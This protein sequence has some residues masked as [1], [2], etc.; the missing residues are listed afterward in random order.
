VGDLMAD[1]EA[2]IQSQRLPS[3]YND[4]VEAV[5][6]PVAQAISA[7]RAALGRPLVAGICGAQGSGKSTLSLFLRRLLEDEGLSVAILSL[8]DLYLTLAQREVLAQTV[9]P[10]LRTRGVPGTHDT[11]LGL[12]LFDILTGGLATEASL[13][14]FDKAA[15]DRAP[16]AT[17]PRIQAPVDVVLFEGW[18]VG[19]RPQAA[20][21]LE[22]PV[23]H[24]ERDQDPTGAWRSY[25]NARLGDDYARL[26]ARID[27]LAL[28][29][30]P[31]FETVFD[32]R[33]L[34]ERKLAERLAREGTAG[35]AVMDA[36]QLR[37]FLM[38]YQRLTEHVLAEMPGRA[39]IV[40]P[41]DAQQRIL[42]VQMKGRL[43]SS[44][45]PPSATPRARRCPCGPDR[46]GSRTRRE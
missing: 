41:M 33:A 11:D 26:F 6:R 14:C 20:A 37:V 21:A 34:Q 22:K 31:G 46:T 4:T 42:A 36:D 10:L 18:C 43:R 28:L 15:D 5:C 12:G 9:H 13:P 1:L 25:V 2:L 16:S 32:W 30:A 27:L 44:P 23:N 40:M 45:P 19:A 38:H 7:R 8:D 29:Q 3:A 24:L 17:W 39:D 35:R